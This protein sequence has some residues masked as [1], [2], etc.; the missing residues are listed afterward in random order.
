VRAQP[1]RAAAAS[2]L[3]MSAS[4]GLTMSVGPAPRSRSSAVATK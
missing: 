2:W 4:S 3:R 1:E